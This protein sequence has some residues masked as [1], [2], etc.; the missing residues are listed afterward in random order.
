[1]TGISLISLF[2]EFPFRIQ[3]GKPDN[4]I[5][6][7]IIADSRKVEPG[8]LFVA[9]K[10][11]N[12]DAHRFIPQALERGAVAVVGME[13]GIKLQVP[14]I[15]VENSR[16]GLAYLAASKYD[17]PARK[18]TV[19]G[20]TGT[21]GKTTTCNIL[22]EI[23]V[24]AG[25]KTGMITTVNAVIGGDVFDTGFHVTTPDALEVQAY[26]AK[27]VDSGLTHVI[28]ETTSHGWAQYRVDA[29][30]IDVGIVT[31]ITH[32]H[33]D[34][35][36]SYS[37]YRAAKARMLETLEVT[38]DKPWGN[39]RL[40]VLNADDTSFDYLKSATPTSWISYGKTPQAQVIPRNIELTPS[41]LQFIAVGPDWEL[42]VQSKLVGEFNVYNI[43][44]ALTGAIHGLDVP[45]EAAA[46]GVTAMDGIPGRMEPIDLGQSFTALVDFAHTPNALKNA[47]RT[48]KMMTDGQVITVFGSAG[49]RDR[50]KRRMMAEVS[51]EMADLS[52][53]TAEDPRTESLDA[54]LSEMGLGAKKAGGVK[55]ETY[56]TVADRGEAIR[57]S[58]RLANPGD[59]V[60][61]CGKGH[62]QSMCFGDVEYPWDDRIA[63]TA[64]LAEFLG[65]E[66]PQMPVLP[67]SPKRI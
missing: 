4:T 14:Y 23:L 21:D 42:P 43:L 50:E 65:K 20:V 48:A 26:L 33:L 5:I 59:V 36:G 57:F 27:M 3:Q 51:V 12:F 2:N 61:V 44:A 41:G 35:H 17:H 46:L 30:E 31:N 19:V 64:A 40:A 24:A 60:V 1:M 39:P 28:L 13:P 7:R 29:C 54:I 45:L 52:V 22:Y 25:F 32:E 56:W 38:R 8:D 15:Q 6:R 63:L 66:G 16:Q 49:L 67:T 34:E 37:K 53:I 47:I 18:L 10:G 62:E 9:T 58:L 11:G 55:D